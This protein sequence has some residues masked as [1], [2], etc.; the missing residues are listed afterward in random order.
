MFLQVSI[1]KLES[2]QLSMI[3]IHKIWSDQS[4]QCSENLTTLNVTDCSNLKYLLSISMAGCLVNLQNL[5]VSESEK[6]ENIFC[7][8]DPKVCEFVSWK[9][10][11]TIIYNLIA[12]TVDFFY[13][14]NYQPF[15]SAEK[16]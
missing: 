9:L 7:P 5:L 14:I 16:Y 4:L 11:F 8:E 1:P 10:N 2:L 13:L 15:S 6:M 3:N 12:Q